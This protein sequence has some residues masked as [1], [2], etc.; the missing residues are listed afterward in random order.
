MRLRR[1]FEVIALV[2]LDPHGT[3]AHHT[4]ELPCS[5]EQ[6]LACCDE[7]EKDRTRDEQ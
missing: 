2:D 4:E 7:I 5:G 3:R 6:V 1:I